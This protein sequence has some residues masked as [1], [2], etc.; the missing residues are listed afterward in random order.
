M[1]GQRGG[2]RAAILA[3]EKISSGLCKAEDLQGTVLLHETV[4]SNCSLQ[5]QADWPA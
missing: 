1:V 2:I 3:L 5:L 4:I